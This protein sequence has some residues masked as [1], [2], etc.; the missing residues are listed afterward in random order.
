MTDTE[1]Y[2]G[3]PVGIPAEDSRGAFR[4][5]LP[6][7]GEQLDL[8]LGIT[9]AAGNI[10]EQ[11]GKNIMAGGHPGSVFTYEPKLNTVQVLTVYPKIA[12][13]DG[14]MFKMPITF[15]SEDVDVGIHSIMQYAFKGESNSF[16]ITKPEFLKI[17][18]CDGVRI[19]LDEEIIETRAPEV[20][21]ISDR[22]DM[23][24][25]AKTIIAGFNGKVINPAKILWGSQA[26]RETILFGTY[27]QGISGDVHVDTGLKEIFYRGRDK[28][29]GFVKLNELPMDYDLV[30]KDAQ[31]KFEHTL[32]ISPQLLGVIGGLI[33]GK[34]HL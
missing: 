8:A 6:L 25:I 17:S 18:C 19:N 10:F 12:S 23:Q 2:N 7:E 30:L 4:Y 13:A 34:S 29:S 20:Q 5:D 31:Q 27:D 32:T 11:I 3:F 26:E 15:S 33:R 22:P 1:Y 9:G 16:N 28:T 24:R 21:S 14:N